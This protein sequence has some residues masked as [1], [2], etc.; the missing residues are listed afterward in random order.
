MYLID[1]NIFLEILL[2]QEKSEECQNLLSG[3]TQSDIPFYVSSFALHSV[4]V[5]MARNNKIK[6]LTSLLSDIS[7]SRIM[8]L[9]S[10][11]ND[12][13]KALE[14]IG[15]LKLDFDDSLQFVLC[16]KYNLKLVSFDRH[17]DKTPVKRIEPRDVKL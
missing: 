9:D 14:I 10:N 5:I 2:D 12:E 8:R 16:K 13:L 11:T 3:I 17:F 6:E 1:T 7:T 15:K 4:E